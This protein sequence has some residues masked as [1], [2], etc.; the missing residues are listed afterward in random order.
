MN[1]VSKLRESVNKCVG[2]TI[3]KVMA[4]GSVGSIVTLHIGYDLGVLFI[5]C[6]WRLQKD[7]RV[8]T[9]SNESCEAVVGDIPRNLEIIKDQTITEW[10]LSEFYDAKISFGNGSSLSIF[11]DVT[12]NYPSKD[13][14][15]NWC[16]CL[17][18]ENSSTR[19][20]NDFSI[21]GDIYSVE[22]LHLTGH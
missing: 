21:K 8:L 15:E 22:L 3:T 14:D 10:T 6:T 16:I 9:G 12:P 2:S 11:C 18:R 19:V 7:G 5:Y 13:Y 20:M 17:P 4:G 1:E